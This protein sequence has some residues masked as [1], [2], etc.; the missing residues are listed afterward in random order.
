MH[1]KL[2]E[3]EQSIPKVVEG[4]K[5]HKKQGRN[6]WIVNEKNDTKD[7]WNKKIVFVLWKNNKIKFDFSQTRSN[8]TSVKQD[9]IWLQSN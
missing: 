4:N 2:L 9:Q 5:N 7:Q 1:F 3:Q 8:L 6:Q